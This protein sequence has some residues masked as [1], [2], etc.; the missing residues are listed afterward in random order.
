MRHSHSQHPPCLGAQRAVAAG[1]QDPAQRRGLAGLAHQPT[2]RRRAMHRAR[3]RTGFPQS[4]C[5]VLNRKLQRTGGARHVRLLNSQSSASGGSRLS[6]RVLMI[7]AAV[8]LIEGRSARSCPFLAAGAA[9]VFSTLCAKAVPEISFPIPVDICT[10]EWS[11]PVSVPSPPPPPPLDPAARRAPLQSLL[12]QLPPSF[13]SCGVS[14]TLEADE[15][16]LQGRYRL[17]HKKS[18]NRCPNSRSRARRAVV[19]VV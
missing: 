10:L 1:P 19:P 16:K 4:T 11:A 15:Q 18:L 2:V 13:P 12:V 3:A 14:Q 5:F 9:A 7:E 17:S 8:L 6:E